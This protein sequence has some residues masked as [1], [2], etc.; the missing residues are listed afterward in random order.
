LIL[1]KKIDLTKADV[2]YEKLMQGS[3][4][5]DQ[6][7]QQTI[8]AKQA[9]FFKGKR[10]LTEQLHCG[11]MQYMDMIDILRKHIW[12][13]HTGNWHTGKWLQQHIG[14][15]L[16]NGF[17]DGLYTHGLHRTPLKMKNNNVLLQN[18]KHSGIGF[19]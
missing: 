2:L 13:K 12:A 1:L 17:S 4:S 3:M 14:K 8:V 5:A 10:N 7:G 19:Q 9:I 16:V 11:Y 6:I 15:C 18:L